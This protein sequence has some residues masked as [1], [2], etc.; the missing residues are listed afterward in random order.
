M[1]RE[2]FSSVYYSKAKNSSR[3]ITGA[4][5]RKQHTLLSGVV[6]TT[7]S[8]L[9]PIMASFIKTKKKKKERNNRV[10]TAKGNRPL[11]I[12]FESYCR[13]DT[14]LINTHSHAKEQL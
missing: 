12:R 11:S 14:A 3:L 9:L 1:K 13:P 2:P 6:Q 7:R 5:E 4:W 8:G 10:L